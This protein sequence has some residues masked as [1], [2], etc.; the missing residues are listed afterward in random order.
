MTNSRIFV[1]VVPDLINLDHEGNWE[2]KRKSN[3]ANSRSACIE[4]VLH[5]SSRPISSY[6]TK[7]EHLTCMNH[8]TKNSTV[9]NQQLKTVQNQQSNTHKHARSICH[10]HRTPG[11]YS[12]CG[13]NRDTTSRTRSRRRRLSSKILRK[14][15]NRYRSERPIQVRH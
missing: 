1:V 13:T 4:T 14:E 8:H 6:Y 10:C 7:H 11:L 15:I 2:M 5:A 9:V 3:R 12:S